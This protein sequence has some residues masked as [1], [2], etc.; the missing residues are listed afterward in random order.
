MAPRKFTKLL[1]PVFAWLRGKGHISTAFLDDSL[2]MADSEADCVHNVVDTIHL[3]RSL[4]FIIHPEKSVLAC[5]RAWKRERQTDRQTEKDR[6]TERETQRK[7]R[8]RDRQTQRESGTET[9][10]ERQ[11]Q[12]DTQRAIAREKERVGEGERAIKNTGGAKIKV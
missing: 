11:R 5:V 6:D 12:N 10:T 1:K 3:L 8:D 9:D 2:L 7:V 4:G